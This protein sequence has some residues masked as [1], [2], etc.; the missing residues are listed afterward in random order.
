MSKTL[1]ITLLGS[2]KRGLS[3]DTTPGINA[4]AP[5]TWRNNLYD[6][7]TSSLHGS[8]DT[9][10]ATGE[11]ELDILNWI[12]VNEDRLP[13]NCAAVQGGSLKGR[14]VPLKGSSE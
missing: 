14:T 8:K 12:H 4:S 5:T 13:S 2:R 3:K 11:T 7:S 9:K 1:I 6:H 10:Q